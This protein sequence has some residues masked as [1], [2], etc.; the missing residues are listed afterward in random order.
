[1]ANEIVA[2]A[3]AAKAGM[4][5]WR[6][7]DF[8]DRHCQGADANGISTGFPTLNEALS[9]QGWPRAGMMELLTNAYGIGELRLLAPGLAELSVAENRWIAWVGPPFVPYAPAW[10]AFGV[11]LAK[12]LWIRPKNAREGVWAAEQALKTG[13]CSAVLGWL[14]E[15]DLSFSALRRLLLAARR[16]AAWACLFRPASAAVSASAAELRLRLTPRGDARLRVDVVKRRGGW[17]LANIEL[18]LDPD[19]SDGGSP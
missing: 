17:P 7:R 10:Q 12:M 13:A 16:G 8:P 11:D 3:N 18:R 1:M 19:S 4:G 14:P 6:A 9:H 15:A 5:L 2:L